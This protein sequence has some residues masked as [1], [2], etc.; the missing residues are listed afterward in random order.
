MKKALF[1]LL[2]LMTSVAPLCA[3]YEY[4]LV[5]MLSDTIVV[6][7][8][9]KRVDNKDYYQV[10]PGGK[11]VKQVF[12]NAYCLERLS[13]APWDK[14]APFNGGMDFVDKTNGRIPEEKQREFGDKLAY[15][16]AFI[17]MEIEM[18]PNEVFQKTRKAAAELLKGIDYLAC[19]SI[20]AAKTFSN[21][22]SGATSGGGGLGLGGGDLGLGGGGLG[23]GGGG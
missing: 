15:H 18:Q 19:Q 10:I 17:P 5:N 16:Y 4:D 1:L 6:K 2:S 7:I 11:T 9:Q 13:W 21:P 23:L 12:N 8:N 3:S 20:D 14:T 22:L